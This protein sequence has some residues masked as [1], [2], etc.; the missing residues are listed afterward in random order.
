MEFL[1]K[2]KAVLLVLMLISLS[3]CAVDRS[4]VSVDAPENIS[5]PSNGV[6]VKLASVTD[7]RVYEFQ[8]AT[9][10][11]PSLS[12]DEIVNADIKARAFA[13]K[14]NSYGKALGDVILPEDQTVAEI[15]K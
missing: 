10:D 15:M 9:P 5:N 2:T 4:T 7:G 8:P 11:I 1:Q 3:A 6:E 13:R 14:R 12:E